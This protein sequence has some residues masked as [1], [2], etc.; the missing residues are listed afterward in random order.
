MKRKGEQ[1]GKQR[2]RDR[3]ERRK[4]EISV[5]PKLQQRTELPM[6]V[7]EHRMQTSVRVG[8]GSSMSGG[9]TQN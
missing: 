8:P 3:G 1:R 4:N 2:Q 6:G 5:I 7:V 9:K